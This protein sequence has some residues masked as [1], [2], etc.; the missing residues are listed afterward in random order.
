MPIRRQI[1]LQT[2]SRASAA[3]ASAL[4]KLDASRTACTAPFFTEGIIVI[5]MPSTTA[6]VPVPDGMPAPPDQPPVEPLPD[7]SVLAVK[8]ALAARFPAL[9]NAATL[10]I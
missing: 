5:L 10:N 1:N 3:W 9:S 6:S 7:E 4:F 2:F 8:S